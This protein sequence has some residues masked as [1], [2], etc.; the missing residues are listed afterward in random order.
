[1]ILFRGYMVTAGITHVAKLCSGKSVY[2]SHV[3]PWCFFA[4]VYFS[5]SDYNNLVLAIW[6]SPLK[7]IYSGLLIF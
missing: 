3:W 4:S 1:M 2:E 7:S 5:N 6:M